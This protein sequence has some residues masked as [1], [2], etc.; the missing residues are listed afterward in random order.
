V[1]VER[2]APKEV[3]DNPREQRTQEF[4]WKVL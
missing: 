3:L 4:L 2:G 1:V